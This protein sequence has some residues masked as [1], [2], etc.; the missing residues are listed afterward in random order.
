MKKNLGTIDAIIRFVI[1]VVLAVLI[2]QGYLEG[3][4]AIVAGIIAGMLVIT[5]LLGW[6][7]LYALLGIRTCPKKQ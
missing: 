5:G 3:V 6:C 1:A 4:G 7:G 2:Y